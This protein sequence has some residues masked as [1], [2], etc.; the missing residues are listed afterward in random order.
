MIVSSKL[1]AAV[2][3]RCQMKSVCG[4]G[5]V[6]MN[7]EMSFPASFIFSSF[8]E[9]K[10]KTIYILASAVTAWSLRPWT[11]TWTSMLPGSKHAEESNV[12]SFKGRLFWYERQC[13]KI[14]NL[15]RKMMKDT[16]EGEHE[17]L[18]RTLG[19]VGRAITGCAAFISG[20]FHSFQ[21]LVFCPPKSFLPFSQLAKVTPRPDFNDKNCFNFCRRD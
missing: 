5:C 9:Y 6:M 21:P 12:A 1:S 10:T 11:I 16:K 15:R 4:V 14:M 20:P 19:T 3:P 8:Q 13:P 2:L 18:V 17:A 7:S